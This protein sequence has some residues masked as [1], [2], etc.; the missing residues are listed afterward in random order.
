MIC[1]CVLCKGLLRRDDKKDCP[2]S[3]L[4]GTASAYLFAFRTGQCFLQDARGFIALLR[5]IKSRADVIVGIARVIVVGIAIVVV[6]IEQPGIGS[7]IVI[8]STFEER[9]A[10]IREVRVVPV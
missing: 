6:E 2:C 3:L 5:A 9:I 7:I 8:A 10:R 1:F 4:R